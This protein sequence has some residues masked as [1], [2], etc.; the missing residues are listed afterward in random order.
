M[1]NTTNYSWETPDDTDLVK[2]GAAAIRTLGS[3]IDT[4]TKALNPSTTLGDIEYRSSTANTN[5][6]LAIGTTGQVL[7]VSGGVPAWSTPASGST[8]VG[9][10]ATITSGISFANATD[11]IVDFGAETYDTNNF[12]DNTTNPSRLTIP[13]GKA[14]YYRI[15]AQ[16]GWGAAANG[17]R[18]IKIFKNGASVAENFGASNGSGNISSSNVSVTLYLAE[19]DYLQVDGYQDSGGTLTLSNTGIRNYFELAYLGA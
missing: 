10:R 7:T 5:T 17:V 1:A 9:V 6:R 19:G 13:S 11:I 2:D 4:T 16:L 14:G 8:F 15:S 3:A 12:H 18:L